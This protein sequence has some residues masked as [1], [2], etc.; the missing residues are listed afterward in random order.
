MISKTLVSSLVA[1]TALAALTFAS[2]GPAHAQIAAAIG[3]PLPVS[4][5][6]TG[7]V[8]V[9]VVNGDP[10][11]PAAGLDVTL[12]LGAGPRVSRTAADGRATFTAVPAGAEAM[13]KI[14]GKDGELASQPFTMPSSGGVRVLMSTTG[15]FGKGGG[16]EAGGAEAGG[17]AMGGG[18]AQPSLRQRSG[19]AIVAS[20]SPATSLAIRLSYD[21]PEDPTPPKD[22]PVH[23]VSYSFDEKISLVTKNSN[24]EGRV[25]FDGLDV[26]GA[27]AYFAMTLLPRGET[28]ERLLSGPLMM[29]GG[30][31]LAMVLSAE[32]RTSTAPGV[33][34]LF[35]VQRFE[36]KV[37]AGQ[38]V[39]E[40]QGEPELGAKITL[41]DVA[42]GKEL[43][44]STLAAPPPGADGKA[45]E[46]PV[47][48]FDASKQIPGQLVY[49]EGQMRGQLYR[50]LPFQLVPDRGARASL[51]VGPRVMMRFSLTSA[52]DE[53][54]FVFRGRFQLANN[55]W[56][57]YKHSDDGLPFPLP[58]GASGAQVT[59]EDAAEISPV[60]GMGLRLLRPLAPGGKT[61]IAGWSMS[62][63]SGEVRWDLE[64]PFGTTQSGMEIMQPSGVT[65]ELPPGVEGRTVQ[66]AKGSYFILPDI[67]IRAKQRMVMTIR[68]LPSAPAWKLWMPRVVG[69][70]VVM[71]LIGGLVFAFRKGGAGG[72]L[73]E[74]SADKA[75]R[76]K[77]DALM[78]EL[79]S[80]EGKRDDKATARRAEVMA[81]LEQ[82]WPTGAAPVASD[83][84]T[85]GADAKASA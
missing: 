33:D 5:D 11:A 40:A 43:L 15:S 9:R 84:P 21:D 4:S 54:Y 26:S 3:N 30:G 62:T 19:N 70:M 13:I 58:V 37:P 50:S 55:S 57:P 56:F 74:E 75:S 76:A 8:I 67:S 66:V 38:V 73:A 41:R 47:A 69:G 10:S 65:V 29:P 45:G 72:V 17:G 77:I 36:G 27:T 49:A 25:T 59:E 2:V 16:A 12:E 44:A 79:V 28:F 61:F 35:T 20:G 31:G 51:L 32:K 48:T 23:L 82:L 81:Q 78:D 64:L 85:S 18:G 1:A 52:L 83:S 24:A 6:A 53:D 34:D 68:G 80:L 7:Q 22:Q 60:P 42:N 14:P 46:W 63:K 71:I 39:I